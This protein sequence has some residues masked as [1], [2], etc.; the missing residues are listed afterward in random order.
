MKDFAGF[1][2]RENKRYTLNKEAFNCVDVGMVNENRHRLIFLPWN[3]KINEEYYIALCSY[4]YLK[5]KIRLRICPMMK[6]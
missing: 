4:K 3:V 1:F 5:E 2:D 6:V